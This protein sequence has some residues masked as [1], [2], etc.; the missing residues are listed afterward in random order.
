MDPNTYSLNSSNRWKPQ[1]T[2]Q[3]WELHRPSDH[4]FTCAALHGHSQVGKETIPKEKQEVTLFPIV[5]TPTSTS[6]SL[7]HRYCSLCIFITDS[8]CSVCRGQSSFDIFML[9][10]KQATAFPRVYYRNTIKCMFLSFFFFFFWWLEM[11]T[12]WQ[13]CL[14]SQRESCLFFPQTWPWPWC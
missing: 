7:P 1:E 13:L 5:Y 12:L 8:H 6:L 9:Y 3:L 14:T 2:F 11:D 10:F 4:T